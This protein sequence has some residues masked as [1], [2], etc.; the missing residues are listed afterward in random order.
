MNFPQKLSQ[1]P[2]L[3]EKFT[4]ICGVNIIDPESVW[5]TPEIGIGRGTTIYPNCY[6]VGDAKSSIGEN[7]EI[8]PRAYLR[9]WFQIGNRV[10][11]GFNAEVVR[12]SV[13]HETKIPHFC[14]VGD[15]FIGRHCN[16]AAG[17]EIANYDGIRKHKTVIEDFVFVGIG[18][19][20]IAPVRIRAHA[21]IGA[22]AIV[23]KDVQP[24]SLIVGVNKVVE[25]KK[26]YY[27]P[28]N[29][30][31]IYPIEKHPIWKNRGGC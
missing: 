5:V 29:G 14:H 30:W 2:G 7:C 31:Y 6:L 12:S 11:I 3:L 27:W 1:S 23:S 28:E 21:Y 25:E 18:A 22:G 13:G 19:K 24:Y 16:I 8:G 17:V 9:D 26:S 10:K 20:I 4:G 15:A